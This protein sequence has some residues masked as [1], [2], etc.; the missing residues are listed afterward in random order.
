MNALELKGGMMEQIFKIQD[1]SSLEE[2]YDLIAEFVAQRG[3]KDVWEQIPASEKAE[4][5][6]AYEES[7]DESNLISNDEMLKKYGKWLKQ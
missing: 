2:L 3:E 6:Q 7:L 5:E 1:K 4:I